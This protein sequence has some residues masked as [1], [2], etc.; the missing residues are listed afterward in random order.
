MTGDGVGGEVK[1]L[2]Q[3]IKRH[4]EY[5]TQIDR[6]LDKSEMVKNEGRRLMEERNFMSHEVWHSRL[7]V[8]IQYTTF[9]LIFSQ[10]RVEDNFTT[11]QREPEFKLKVWDA[12]KCIQV[13]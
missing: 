8:G 10:G 13:Y 5:R 12:L 2:E 1:D 9:A 3:L 11:F 7:K 4:E 6:Q